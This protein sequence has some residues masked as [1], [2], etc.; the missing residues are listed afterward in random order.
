L[1]NLFDVRSLRLG[2]L[3]D[4]DSDIASELMRFLAAGMKNCEFKVFTRPSHEILY[5]VR[6]RNIDI[7]LATK[8]L[9]DVSDLV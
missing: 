1:G 3:E 4:F 2:L 6:N 8:P 7:G 9:D 5:M